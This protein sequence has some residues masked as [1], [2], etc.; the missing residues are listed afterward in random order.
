M[1]SFKREAGSLE[2]VRT[3]A[4]VRKDKNMLHCSIFEIEEGATKVT[5]RSQKREE[6]DSVSAPLN[7]SNSAD[8]LLSLL[9]L[10][11]ESYKFILL[12][13]ME[14]MVLCYSSDGKLTLLHSLKDRLGIGNTGFECRTEFF[15]GN[16][17]EY[18]I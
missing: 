3:E 15:M 17:S 7:R 13:A 2:S 18:L 9:S 11:R 8:L 12:S 5:S 6:I 1:G 16:P 4:E 14:Y 10:E